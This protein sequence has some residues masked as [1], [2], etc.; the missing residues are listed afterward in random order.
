M[1]LRLCRTLNTENG[2]SSRL[3]EKEEGGIGE[4]PQRTFQAKREL[5]HLVKDDLGQM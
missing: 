3:E 1:T 4:G 5:G 2:E